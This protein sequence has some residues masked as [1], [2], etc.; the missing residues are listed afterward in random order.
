MQALEFWSGYSRI[1]SVRA[2]LASETLDLLNKALH[3]NQKDDQENEE[4][5][6]LNLLWT[7]RSALNSHHMD[8]LV[9]LGWMLHDIIIRPRFSSN[10]LQKNLSTIIDQYDSGFDLHNENEHEG[11][12]SCVPYESHEKMLW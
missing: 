4:S 12:H 1:N 3:L 6:P 8:A 5:S 7:W 11:D 10:S 9:A 2:D